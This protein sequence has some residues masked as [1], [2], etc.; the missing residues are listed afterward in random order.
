ML[1]Q[2][3]EHTQ[4]QQED[5]ELMKDENRILKGGEKTTYLYTKQTG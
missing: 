1:E 3:I 2:L 4:K 5:I